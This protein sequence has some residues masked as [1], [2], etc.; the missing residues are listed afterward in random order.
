MKVTPYIKR[1]TAKKVFRELGVYREV[2]GRG[3]PLDKDARQRNHRRA[4]AAMTLGYR[5]NS[6]R[7]RPRYEKKEMQV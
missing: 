2:T 5:L 6:K 7:M 4:R 3:L 1:A